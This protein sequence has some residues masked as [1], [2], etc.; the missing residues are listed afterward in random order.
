MSIRNKRIELNRVSKEINELE[1]RVKSEQ[2]R[3]SNLKARQIELTE[4]LNTPSENVGV[5][6]HALIRYLERKYGFDFT[7]YRN[8]ILTPERISAI[9]SGAES[10]SVNGVKMKIQNNTVVTVI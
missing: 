4:L 9:K 3:L 8:E 2:R 5:S 6:D 7:D 10:I 1:P